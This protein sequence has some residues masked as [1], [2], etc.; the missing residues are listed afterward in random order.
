MNA[1]RSLLA[2]AV[3]ATFA[4]AQV[5]P[6]AGRTLQQQQQ[7]PVEAP[8]A[9][10]PLVIP[11]GPLQVPAP[12]GATVVLKS[13]AFHGNTRLA[14]AAL[15]AIVHDAIGRPLD[16]AGLW[17]VAQRVS[18]A[19]RAAGYPFARAYLPPQELQDGALRIE[20][21]EGR[22][23]RVRTT[24]DASLA[25]S[26]QRW[27][28]R[29]HPGD[30]IESAP[31]ERAAM[32]LDD[33]PGVR[34][35]PIV[36]PG[37]QVGTGDLDVDIQRGP[38]LQGSVGLDNQ[39]NKY[40]GPTR[41]Q[42][43]L[44]AG[45]PFMA[46]DQATLH[47]MVT[48]EKLWFGSLGYSLPINANGWRAHAELSRTHYQ[49]GSDFR[50]LRAS[51]TAKVAAVGSSYAIERSQRLDV[52]VDVALQRKILNDVQGAS[53]TSDGKSSNSLPMVVNFDVRDGWQG[54]GLTW[55]ALTLTPGKLQLGHTLAVVDAST[56]RTNGHYA[57]L[58]LDV[59]RTQAAGDDATLFVRVAAQWANKNLDSSEGFGIGGVT[60]VRAYPGG[61]GYGDAGWLAQVEYRRNGTGPQ[62]YLLFDAGRTRT[63][64]H[65]WT[66]EDNRRAL[67]GV[68]FGVR[69]A[70]D[71]FSVDGSV[72]WRAS[73]GPATS[74]TKARDPQLWLSAS[75]AF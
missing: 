56:A 51:G 34:A 43:D 45:S 53:G 75:M 2:L 52:S 70:I 24:G 6:D 13:V 4:Q 72:A 17:G 41:L 1:Q 35:T 50:S 55:G 68:G 73:G 31:L 61:E 33:L 8:R 15:Q 18:D 26:A 29:L 20:I 44:R 42:M 62:P 67:S 5:A 10:K 39:G 21:V 46:G 48:D 37:E 12:G 66:N 60:G 49:L 19:Y 28:Q 7:A 38:R 63:N 14:D 59:S 47:T 54:G 65:P 27:L 58:D 25:P 40:T 23:G 11:A 22:Y 69:G 30:V 32:L 64:I 74:E 57:R 16:L 36:K 71:R 9:T 3:V